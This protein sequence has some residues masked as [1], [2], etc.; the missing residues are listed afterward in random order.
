MLTYLEKLLTNT[1]TVCRTGIIVAAAIS[2]F[3]F[4][5]ISGSVFPC[6]TVGKSGVGSVAG[7]HTVCSTGA[8]HF[9]NPLN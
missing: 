8:G 5:V 2:G 7:G 4:A 1:G 9:F 3:P 6:L